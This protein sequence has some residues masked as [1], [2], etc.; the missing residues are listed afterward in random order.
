MI[1]RWINGFDPTQPEG[2]E[3]THQPRP[4]EDYPEFIQAEALGGKLVE[5]IRLDSANRQLEELR[6][7][8]DHLNDLVQ[9]HINKKEGFL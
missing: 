7:Q 1:L 6:K 4:A 2:T 9:S 5:Y 8:I 3:M